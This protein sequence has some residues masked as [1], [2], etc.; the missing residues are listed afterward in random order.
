[1]V[2]RAKSKNPNAVIAVLG[3]SVE[4]SKE[5]LAMAFNNANI[6]IGNANKMDAISFIQ[7]YITSNCSTLKI[8]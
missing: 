4:S 7:E 6:L 2:S 8:Y 3:C 5:S 1:M